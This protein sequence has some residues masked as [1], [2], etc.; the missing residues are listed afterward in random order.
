V[1]ERIVAGVG[2]VLLC[3]ASAL[4]GLVELSLVP[5][6]LGSYVLPV[7]VPLALA[8][9]WFLPRLARGLVDVPA[10]MVAVVGAWLVPIVILA[11]TPRPE[12]DVYVP[13]GSAVQWVFYATLFGGVVV[14]TVSV[15]LT[16]PAAPPA[17][18]G[19]GSVR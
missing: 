7:A 11:L 3:L 10:V 13:A 16:G 2:L 1:S 9:N 4:A 12:G 19:P 6:Y 14:G 18:Q 17:R 5:L 15:V 8:G